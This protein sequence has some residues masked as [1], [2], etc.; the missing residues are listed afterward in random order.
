[1]KAWAYWALVILLIVFG[2][3]A[4]FSIG[5]PFFLLGLMLALVSPWRARRGVVATGT[6]V[7]L[8]F[9]LGYVL[10]APL[11]CSAT[12]FAVVGGSMSE[13]TVTCSSLLWRYE[14]TGNYNP[15][16]IPGLFAGIAGATIAG[17]AAAWSYFGRRP[18][19]AADVLS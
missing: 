9:V 13:S 11:S 2:Y 12:S 19:A 18:R 10:V 5:A 7:I 8:G 14:G 17:G 16:L 6:A 3:L 15:S 4:I 1:M